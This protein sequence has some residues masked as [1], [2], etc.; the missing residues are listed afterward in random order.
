MRTDIQQVC[1]I[2]S[3]KAPLLN[4]QGDRS[5][6]PTPTSH[7]STL[8]VSLAVSL[9]RSL[10]D[11][12]RLFLFFSVSFSVYACAKS[13]CSVFPSLVV[14]VGSRS[15]CLCVCR[16]VSVCLQYRLFYCLH[17]CHLTVHVNIPVHVNVRTCPRHPQIQGPLSDSNETNAALTHTL[18]PLPYT[19]SMVY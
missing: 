10:A 1:S 8:S 7:L 3:R 13:F 6:A 12:L 15:V 17:S 14:L 19:L 16:C 2:I 11:S 4:K 18:S 5:R 9:T